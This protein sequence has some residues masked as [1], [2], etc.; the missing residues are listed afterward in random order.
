MYLSRGNDEYEPELGNF[1]GQ[2]TDE[3]ECY[4]IGSYI[5]GFVSGGP[6]FYALQ[7]L[8]PNGEYHYV[9]KIKGISLN[10]STS[11]KIN[12]ES[13]KS[14]VLNNESLKLNF[15]SIRRT[16][17]HE[18]LTKTNET[19]TVKP[20]QRKRVFRNDSYSVPYGFQNVHENVNKN[21]NSVIP[22]KKRKI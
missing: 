16:K 18:V 5:T 6:K 11:D 12:F 20:N 8:D 4:G 19:K 15:T 2:W 17:N 3:L 1:L 21:N 22:K 13:I 10:Y 7:I 9:Y 14:L